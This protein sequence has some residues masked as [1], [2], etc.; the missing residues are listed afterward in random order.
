M[1]LQSL[2]LQARKGQ[3]APGHAVI[4][5]SGSLDVLVSPSGQ[6][7]WLK[8]RQSIGANQVLRA[9][10]SIDLDFDVRTNSLKAQ[11]TESGFLSFHVRDDSYPDCFIDQEATLKVTIHVYMPYSLYV[12]ILAVLLFS[13]AM[14]CAYLERRKK[15]ADSLWIVKKSELTYDD[16]PEVLGRGTFGLVVSAEYRGT[17]V[18]C[19]FF[20]SYCNNLSQLDRFNNNNQ[21]VKR[22]IPPEVPKES[23]RRSIFD[24]DDDDGSDFGEDEESARPRVT[25]AM[26]ESSFLNFP[27]RRS[28]MMSAT[29][30]NNRPVSR[31]RGS[32][33]SEGSDR[34]LLRGIASG[35]IRAEPKYGSMN[36]YGGS[37][38]QLHSYLHGS[39]VEEM[40]VLSRLRHP[41]IITFMGALVAQNEDP[42]LVMEMMPRGSIYDLIHNST[43]IFEGDIILSIL[44]DVS[45]GMRFLHS[46]SPQIVHGDLKCANVLVGKR[47][48]NAISS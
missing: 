34:R 33:A 35:S 29:S 13:A 11:T 19:F 40:R 14:F 47:Q 6:P 38:P 18:V 25:F 1:V 43:M 42:L 30:S 20:S 44:R 5:N 28:S 41:S 22:V 24:Y 3:T 17:K 12:T 31:R 9:G 45:Q 2:S 37:E 10:E 36:S 26:G 23:K 48:W 32:M 4:R 15:A 39:F 16:P 8:F 27:R 21:A 7:E 46:A